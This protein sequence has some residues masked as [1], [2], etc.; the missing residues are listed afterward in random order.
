MLTDE[1]KLTAHYQ[2]Y[3]TVFRVDVPTTQSQLIES[4]QET[5]RTTSAPRLPNPEVTKGESSDQ[6][7]STVIRIRV[8]QRRQDP[9]TPI[10]TAAEIDVT[11]LAKI[12]QMS[13]ATQRSIK[14]YEA[15]QNV[16]RVKERMVDEEL[17]QLLEETENVKKDADMVIINA[18][19]EEES[20]GDEFE[21]RRREKGKGLEE[22][23]DSPS[24][25]PIRS[26]R[27]HITP[28][29]TDKDTLQELTVTTKDA[30]SSADK[31]KLQELTVTNTTPSSSSQK[32]KSGRIRHYKTF[33][34]QMGEC[35]GYM[36]AHLKQHFVPRKK[37]YQLAKHLHSTMEEILPPMIGDR[38]NEISKKTVPLYVDEGLLLDKQ[39][40]QV[41]VAAMIAD[42]IKFERPAATSC[43]TAAIRPTDHDDHQDDAHPEGRIVR[44]GKKR[45]EHQYHVD[46]MHNYLK[47][48][49]VWESR[50]ERLFLPTPQKPTLVYHSCQRD[51]KAPPMTLLNQDMF[52][53]KF[54][55][56]RQKKYTMSPHKFLAVP[57]HD[58]DM[59]EQ[60]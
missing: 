16:E 48:D 12:I 7:K 8:P 10:P 20:A 2:M 34:Q 9:E 17:E 53:L 25:T 1:M 59:K 27:T 26:I 36:F 58:D 31:E 39:I 14:D 44:R 33:I 51:P 28:L 3:T 22:I 47:N 49:I 60:T 46:Q 50:K 54:G 29:P 38:V 45:E 43:R 42:A 41:D 18:R 6:R 40:T 56:L 24:P 57:F 11:S 15:Q 4:T 13:I 55:K 35:Y 37:F 21:L 30:P 52:Y 19:E 32:P 5:H 23:R